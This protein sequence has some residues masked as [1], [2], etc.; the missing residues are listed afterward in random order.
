MAEEQGDIQDLL[1]M[2]FKTAQDLCDRCEN[3][4]H[5]KGTIIVHQ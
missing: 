1:E 4:A 5:V 2:H 3:Q